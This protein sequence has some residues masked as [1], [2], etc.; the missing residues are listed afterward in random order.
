MPKLNLPLAAGTALIPLILGF[1]W[2]NQKLFGNAWMKAAGVTAEDGK[3][4]N[5][6]VV[7]A[8]TYFFSFLLS[9]ALHFMTIHQFAFGALLEP[10]MGFTDP[11]GFK[12]AITAAAD[13]SAHKFRSWTHGM[14]HGIITGI[15]FVLPL[16]AINAMF[17]LKN[18][19]YILI[20]AGYWTL[21]LAVMGAIICQFA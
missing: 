2:Y 7:F 9:V 15:T 16:L 19:K 12:E 10:A 18:W 17:E 5:M 20:N 11:E 4:M 1:I 3:K 13:I 6:P 21:C 14:V 8:L